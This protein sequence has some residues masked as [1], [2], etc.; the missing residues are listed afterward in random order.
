M[1]KVISL[2]DLRPQAL[3]GY[4]LDHL[5][6]VLAFANVLN[7][8]QGNVVGQHKRL[9]GD[10]ILCKLNILKFKSPRKNPSYTKTK[11]AASHRAKQISNDRHKRSA[12][13]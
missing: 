8:M 13:D 7:E 1:I 9:L 2:K 5:R 3:H 4:S 6:G 11:I 12:F 10:A